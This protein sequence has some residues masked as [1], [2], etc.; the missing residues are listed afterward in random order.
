MSDNNKN[1]P[2]TLKVSHTIDNPHPQQ[3][4]VTQPPQQTEQ[5]NQQQASATAG[6]TDVQG[7]TNVSRGIIGLVTNPNP[8]YITEGT[9]A[10]KVNPATRFQKSGK[11]NPVTDE[12]IKKRMD[13]ERIKAGINSEVQEQRVIKLRT[14][15]QGF[16]YT[17]PDHLKDVPGLAATPDFTQEKEPNPDAEQGES[18]VQV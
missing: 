5:E 13:D 16:K 4:P 3:P 17:P 14:E 8:G 12:D 11:S 7:N 10:D 15:Q 6:A 1:P 2:K 18:E 9:I